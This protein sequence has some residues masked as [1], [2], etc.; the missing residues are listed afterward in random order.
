MLLLRVFGTKAA[1]T[2]VQQRK[3]HHQRKTIWLHS[4]DN[5]ASSNL[6]TMRTWSC[7]PAVNPQVPL[8]R[9][10]MMQLPQFNNRT[11]IYNPA[12]RRGICCRYLSYIALS[13]TT[14]TTYQ[15]GIIAKLR[16][17]PALRNARAT[18]KEHWPLRIIRIEALQRKVWSCHLDPFADTNCT[19]T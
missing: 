6:V 18:T 3:I 2:H 14:M 4:Q 11:E 19:C 5:P 10:I 13:R 9:T 1:V 8:L 15:R 7:C 16:F 17:L 12:W